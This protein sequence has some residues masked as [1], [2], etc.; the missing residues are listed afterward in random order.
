M[1]KK[2][3]TEEEIIILKQNKYVKKVTSKGITYT[4]EF[5]RIFIDENGNG[6]LPR[7]IF[8][9]CGF[10][11][12]IIGMQR[13][14]SSASRW[15]TAFKNGGAIKLT[16]TRKYNTGRPIEKDLSIEEKY[17]K[18]E[19]K[20]KLL[21]AENELPKK[22]RYDRNESVKEEVSLFS[23]EKYEI[24][25]STIKKYNLKN[26]ISYLC[27]VAGV[28]RSGYYKYFSSE[29]KDL[30]KS[31]E[32]KDILSKENVLKDFNFKGRKKGARQIKMV[33]K[34]RFNIIYN[35]KRIR[36]IMKKYGIVC[37]YRKANPYRRMMKA[38]KEHTVVSNLINREFKQDI[39]YKVLLT[40]ITY[41]SY[42]NGKKAY[43]STIKDSSTN[44]ILAHYVSDNLRLDIVLNTLE[45]L[46]SNVN[47]KLHSEAIL[48][49]DQGVHYTS[50]KFQKQV[51]QLGLKQSMSRRGNCWDNAPQE[52]FFGHFKD[53]V[54]LSKCSTLEEVIKE[55][56][57]YMDYY[58]N[59]RY[60]W[61]LS[62]M[63]PVQY[64]NHLVS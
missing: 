25:K 30:R 63:T 61:N 48:H 45:K 46:K 53:E 47:L 57:D 64:R 40:D 41:L 59:Y 39:P 62:K 28:S 52:S 2:L 55:I 54:I 18:L 50:P 19:A 51:Q 11:I 7:I 23:C 38:S 42:K 32:D 9:E 22:V 33:L 13:V 27:K 21:Q 43:L 15:R 3:F 5:K 10:N 35:L 37:P 29:S 14:K 34:D 49:S 12:D 44:E 20:M 16:D 24:I 26:M 58:N 31:R 36:R 60:Q 6:K 17:K 1:S 4:D 8:E 56:D